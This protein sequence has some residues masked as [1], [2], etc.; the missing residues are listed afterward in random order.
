MVDDARRGRKLSFD[1]AI[2]AVRDMLQAFRPEALGDLDTLI[3]E[4][5]AEVLKATKLS[6][7]STAY[8]D[9]ADER[10]IGWYAPSIHPGGVWQGLK[11]RMSSSGPRDAV[12]SIDSGGRCG[13]GASRS[14]YGGGDKRRGLVIGNVQSGKT[15]NYAAVIA[16][17]LDEGYKLVIVM[18]GI[19]S[20]LRQ[21]T[22]RRLERD[23][24]T[25]IDRADWHRLTSVDGDIGR[26][27]IKN[28]SGIVSKSDR[29][30][31][32]VKKNSMRLKNLVDFIKAVDAATLANTPILIIDDESDQATPDAS[33]PNSTEP[34]TINQRMREIWKLVG[35]GSYVG[36]TAT[37]FCQCV[38]Q[39]DR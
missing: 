8:D 9:A 29:V 21:E 1:G 12:P 37:P 13:H 19:H 2:S 4:H 38:H 28:A 22:Q 7:N 33:G 5:K 31:A 15:A 18:S 23:L 10:A 27:D 24:G 14:A 34:T 30:L 16:K 36:Y 3:E 39:P 11:T 17:A 25:H 35:N 6:E 20:N 26:A 32:V